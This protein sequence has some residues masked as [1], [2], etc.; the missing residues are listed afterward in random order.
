MYNGSIDKIKKEMTVI[1]KEEV[2]TVIENT[3][4]KVV[5]K[6]VEDDYKVAVYHYECNQI[7]DENKAYF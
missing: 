1:Y 7:Q 4:E 3:G 2:F 6:A 5:L